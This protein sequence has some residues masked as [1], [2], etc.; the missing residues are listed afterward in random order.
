MSKRLIVTL[1]ATPMFIGMAQQ[2]IGPQ[3]LYSDFDSWQVRNIK[4]SFVIGGKVKQI[5]EIGKQDTI[6]DNQPRRPGDSPWETSS[7]LIHAAGVNKASTTVFPEKRGKGYCLRIESKLEEVKVMGMVNLTCMASGSVFTG[8]LIEPIESSE[9]PM[10]YMMQGV[11]FTAKPRAI[12]FDYKAKVG[13]KREYKSVAKSHSLEGA[14]EA[15]ISVVLQKRWEDSN[16]QL[17]AKRVGTAY[18]RIKNSVDSWINGFELPI[19]YGDITKDSDYQDYMGVDY[20]NYPYWGK[21][22]DGVRMQILEKTYADEN[23]SP[24][25]III[26]FSSGYGG[27]FCGAEGDKLWVDNL[28]IMY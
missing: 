18:M 5:Y 25:H 27:A 9:N 3:I 26:R 12:K 28:K 8:Y 15:E 2:E 11:P 24:T 20:E 14:N 7:S 17:H 21:N 13:G 10:Q 1:L 19:K 23:E 4:E 16:G 22:S 6:N